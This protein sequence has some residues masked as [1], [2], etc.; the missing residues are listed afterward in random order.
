VHPSQSQRDAIE[1]DLEATRIS[2]TGTSMAAGA[3]NTYVHVIRDANGKGGPTSAMMTD[4]INVLNFA[5]ATSSRPTTRTTTSGTRP[6]TSAGRRS[7]TTTQGI[8][9]WM[10]S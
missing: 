8:Q 9:R 1:A 2:L 3:I 7:P 4:Q 6:A 10:A 5:Y